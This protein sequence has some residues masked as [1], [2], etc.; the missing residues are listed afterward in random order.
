MTELSPKAK[1]LFEQ[2]Q[3]SFEPDAARLARVRASLTAKL[4]PGSTGG[5]GGPAGTKSLIRKGALG[6][7]AGAVGIGVIVVAVR[8]FSPAPSSPNAPAEER[9]P[10]AV[11]VPPPTR[12]AEVAPQA[13]ASSVPPATSLRP[14]R[15]GASAQPSDVDSLAEE[16]ALMREVRTALSSGNASRAL[17]L[18]DEHARR[19]PRGTLGQERQATRVLALCAAGRVGEARAE[20]ARFEKAAPRSPLLPRIR[21]SCAGQ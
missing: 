15:V 16:L 2:A 21:S 5:S 13:S 10:A 17:T 19:F 8:A 12:V 4:G 14:T 7:L 6:S 18:L 1:A 11:S 3:T 20:A 9:A